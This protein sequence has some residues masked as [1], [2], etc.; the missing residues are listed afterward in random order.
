[1]V[2]VGWI[3]AQIVFKLC[4]AGWWLQAQG[5]GDLE[6][7]SLVV[8]HHSQ[9][10]RVPCGALHSFFFALILGKCKSVTQG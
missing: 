1:M 2:P 10:V 4:N 3:L 5:I 6:V 7:I 8:N 9:R